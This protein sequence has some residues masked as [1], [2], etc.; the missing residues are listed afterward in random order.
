MR[1][2]LLGCLLWVVCILQPAVGQQIETLVS[3]D[4]LQIGDPFEIVLLV[5]TSQAFPDFTIP[6]KPYGEGIGFIDRRRFK[7]GTYRDSVIYRLQYF[8]ISDTVLPG[9]PVDFY[10]AGRD[11]TVRSARIPLFFASVLPNSETDQVELRPLKPNFAFAM[12]LWLILLIAM[13]VLVAALT[14]WGVWR[15]WKGR[16]PEAAPEPMVMAEFEHPI[17]VLKAALDGL[18]SQCSRLEAADFDGFYV[19]LGNAIRAYIERVYEIQALEMTS[20]ELL[21]ALDAYRA[22]ASMIQ[23]TRAVLAEADLVKFAKYTPTREMAAFAVGRARDFLRT[24]QVE[25]RFRIERMR[26]AHLEEQKALLAEYEAAGKDSGVT[27][28]KGAGAAEKGGV[29]VKRATDAKDTAGTT[30]E[31]G[32]A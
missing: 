13:G 28:E 30:R 8:S 18:D 25:D 10:G 16:E 27:T 9:I 24:A 4:S 11:T 14:G 7:T 29:A 5:N 20:S 3:V 15:W 23:S 12:P 6:E 2:A 17:E 31:D 22:Q 26:E 1:K 19:E 21:R 32:D